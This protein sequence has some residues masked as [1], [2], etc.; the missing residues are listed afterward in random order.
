MPSHPVL[1]G[2][3][4]GPSLRDDRDCEVGSLR[5]FWRLSRES[6]RDSSIS[7]LPTAITARKHEAWSEVRDARDLRRANEDRTHWSFA[8]VAWPTLGISPGRP[9]TGTSGRA[10][11]ASDARGRPVGLGREADAALDQFRGVLPRACHRRRISS[12]E[13]RSSSFHGL[14]EPG[15]SS[16]LRDEGAEQIAGVSA[17]ADD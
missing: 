2:Y 9:I 8:M 17:K 10:S 5:A 15:A 4:D 7:H 11:S 16:R 13:G 12:P 3:A 1:G 6:T 14:R